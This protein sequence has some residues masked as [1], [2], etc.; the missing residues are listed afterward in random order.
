MYGMW[1]L[2]K[3]MPSTNPPTQIA[4]KSYPKNGALVVKSRIE[5]LFEIQVLIF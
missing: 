1:S 2:R 5:Y 3:K 4:W